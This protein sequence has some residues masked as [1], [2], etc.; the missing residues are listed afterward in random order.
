MA[1]PKCPRC[2]NCEHVVLVKT[3]TKAGAVAGGVAGAAGA[4]GGGTAGAAAGRG[5]DGIRERYQ[6]NK[7]GAEF[8]G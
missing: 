4:A 5:L 8:D 2:N 3:F 7:C 1:L 6:C